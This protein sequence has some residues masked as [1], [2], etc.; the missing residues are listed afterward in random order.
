MKSLATPDNKAK[1][2][3]VAYSNMS[4]KVIGYRLGALRSIPGK[5]QGD[6]ICGQ[7][8]QTHLPIPTAPSPRVK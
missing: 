8:R 3:N 1:N 7:C 4:K 2:K 5:K 6:F